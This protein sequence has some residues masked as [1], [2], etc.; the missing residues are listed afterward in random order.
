M[1]R[2]HLSI[3]KSTHLLA[4]HRSAVAFG[5]LVRL[6]PHVA[7]A[8]HVDGTLPVVALDVVGLRLL[9]AVVGLQLFGQVDVGLGDHVGVELYSKMQMQ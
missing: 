5:D 7:A 3:H 2:L 4:R 8:V 6:L 1:Y 9:Q